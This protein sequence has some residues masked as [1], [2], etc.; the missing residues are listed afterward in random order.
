[1]LLY[2]LLLFA[3]IAAVVGRPLVNDDYCD[4]WDGSDEPGTSACSYLA[5]AFFPCQSNGRRGVANVSIP[6]SRINDGVCDCCD[7]S[8]ESNNK[9]VTCSDT[10]EAQI[11]DEKKKALE[12]H[13]NIQSGMR[14]RAEIAEVN[15][16][17]R[18]KDS[19]Q[20]AQLRIEYQAI[21]SMLLRMM[22]LLPREE[23]KEAVLRVQLIRER[24]NR[25]ALGVE[26]N[27]D[28]FHPNY[29]ED[30]ELVYDG[31]PIE[32]AN[33]VKRVHYQHTRAEQDH[34]NKA[35]SLERVKLAICPVKALL[36]DEDARIF[37]KVNELLTFAASPGGK[38]SREQTLRQKKLNTLFGR[39]LENG[40]KGVLQGKL[41]LLETLG[42][43]LSPVTLFYRLS[44]YALHSFGVYLWQ[45][46]VRCAQF[47]VS[48]EQAIDAKL[49]GTRWPQ[50]YVE[51][52]QL[53]VQSEV[54]GSVMANALSVLDYTQYSALMS[55]LDVWEDTLITP[56]WMW[57][58][59]YRAPMLYYE[60]YF[61]NHSALLPPRRQACLLRTAI[62]TAQVELAA[63]R[64]RIAAKEL[65]VKQ[66]SRKRYIRLPQLPSTSSAPHKPNDVW[67]PLDFG[68]QGIWESVLNTCLHETIGDHKY[69]FCYFGEITQDSS[70]SLG[71]FVT[72]GNNS[73]SVINGNVRSGNMN[74]NSGVVTSAVGVD[75]ITDTIDYDDRSDSTNVH[76]TRSIPTTITAPLSVSNTVISTINTAGD[77]L[78]AYVRNSIDSLTSHNRIIGLTPRG[79]ALINSLREWLKLP[80]SYGLEGSPNKGKTALEEVNKA[81]IGIE[82]SVL[83]GLFGT[84]GNKKDPFGM[85]KVV[86]EDN[87]DLQQ[88]YYSTQVYEGGTGCW[89]RQGMP[90]K[91]KVIFECGMHSKITNVEET[92]VCEYLFTVS[93]PL[94]CT[95]H[96][97]DT[98]L[99]RLDALG[100]FGFTKNGAS[101]GARRA[102]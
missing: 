2:H 80:P 91:S 95:K 79:K 97:E 90:R 56:S 45:E 65:L 78:L 75:G 85:E 14:A 4:S 29:F 30:D 98:S 5:S 31:Y 27:C 71:H 67:V 68:P 59:I 93:T 41:L 70:V 72:W 3:W 7:G 8:D 12:M 73:T 102:A 63:L 33:N 21:D 77:T 99:Q 76:T 40:N 35:S 42:L 52:C 92:E 89:P 60:Y 19:N 24:E 6:T 54:E 22:I 47:P 11:M 48:P 94:V 32:Y 82:E 10:C 46:A 69:E 83:G 44:Q 101:A 88:V 86:H 81:N 25:C 36:P 74:D 9:L 96:L 13:R 66:N 62:D 39:Y 53:I 49:L 64:D 50:T 17:A 57:E 15:R 58:V 87:L 38:V 28:Y 18:S 43:V 84:N 20:I 34:L 16:Q 37:I 61:T 23:A 51:V 1:M 55:L 26:S 100:V